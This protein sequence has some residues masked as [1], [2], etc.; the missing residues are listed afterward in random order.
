MIY[1]E[2]GELEALQTM[3]WNIPVDFWVIELNNTNP[4]KDRAVSGVSIFLITYLSTSVSEATRKH[5]DIFLTIELLN[6][7]V[8]INTIRFRADITV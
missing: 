8:Y 1:V 6:I 3:N 2:G 4:E 5:H 7:H